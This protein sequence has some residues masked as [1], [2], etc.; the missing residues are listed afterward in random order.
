MVTKATV[1]DVSGVQCKITYAGYGKE[2]DEWVGPDRLTIK[3]MWKGA[4]YPAKVLRQEGGGYMVS[5]DGY[6][7]EFNEVV[8]VS[9]IEAR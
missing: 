4:W 7:S 1:T 6:G 3:V 2:Y 5:Y 9:R 8:P